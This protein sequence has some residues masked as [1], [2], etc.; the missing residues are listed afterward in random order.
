MQIPGTDVFNK[1]I[2]KLWKQSLVSNAEINITKL[3]DTKIFIDIVIVE[4]P[5][6]INFTFEG[7]KKG[8]KDDLTTKSGLSKDRVLTEDMKLSAVEVIR[9][10]YYDKGYRNVTI[11]MVERSE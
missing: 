9:K 8:D 6:L 5:R 10:F 3:E 7:I 11:N 4:R 2:V 1:A